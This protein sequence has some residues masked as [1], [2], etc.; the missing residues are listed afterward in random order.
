MLAATS[1]SAF[2]ASIMA[3]S[4]NVLL[5]TLT[6]VFQAPFAQVQWMVLSF[7]LASISLSP[8]I[9]RLGDLLGKHRL[10]LAGHVAF[11]LG[12]LLCAFA[13]DIGSLIAFRALQGVGAAAL[14]GLGMAII[15]D[16]FPAEQRGRALGLNASVLAVGIVLG[17]SLGGVL[18]ELF[19]WRSVFFLGLLISVAGLSLCYVALPRYPAQRGQRF[20][21]PGSLLLF[22]TLLGLSLSLTLGQ[23]RGLAHPSVLA[24]L[25]AAVVLG[26][27]FVWVETKVASPLLDLRL[28]RQRDLSVGL[29]SGLC[30]F[31]SIGAVILL[32]PF[33]LEGMRGYPTWQVGLLMGVVPCFMAVMAPIGG[34]LSDRFGSRPIT[35]IGLALGLI[36]YLAVGTLD[37]HTSVLGFLLRYLP[38]GLGMGLFQTPNNSAIMGAARK[39][40]SGVAGGLLTV[41]RNLG[42]TI[43]TAVLASLWVTR[44]VGRAGAEL[45]ADVTDL[46]VWAQIAGFQDVLRVTQV[47]IFLALVLVVS[48]L[49]QGRRRS[50]SLEPTG[51]PDPRPR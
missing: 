14:T 16:V 22:C 24:L 1:L 11:G 19:S 25:A 12:A 21:L 8:I 50:G 17:P 33:Y 48:D 29:L 41:T 44:S 7:L 27:V 45:G 2:A 15:T 18:A 43:G 20:D 38:I 36:G 4:V 47:L 34:N 28:F 13:P 39:G 31:I 30:T 49:W 32:L 35:V 5:P 42:H 10:Y 40:G 46:P 26:L 9:G 6:E 37:E 3:T 23:A 51:S